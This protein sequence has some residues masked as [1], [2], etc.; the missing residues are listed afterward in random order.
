MKHLR[1]DQKA[2]IVE[3]LRSAE[4][5]RVRVECEKESHAHALELYEA[6]RSGGWEVIGIRVK[7]LDLPMMTTEVGVHDYARPGIIAHRLLSALRTVGV[8]EVRDFARSEN[9]DS[10]CVCLIV[11]RVV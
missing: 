8:T 3:I 11:G 10:D 6:I 5:G 4:S 1:P 9:A 2:G 7:T